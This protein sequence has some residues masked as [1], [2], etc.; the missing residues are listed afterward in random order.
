MIRRV[1]RE[2]SQFERKGRGAKLAKVRLS[3]NELRDG[4]EN[5]SQ[6]YSPRY[7]LTI[8]TWVNKSSLHCD[9]GNAKFDYHLPLLVVKPV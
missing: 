7:G 3:E 2:K 1:D 6:L 4:F 8:E 9:H 5:S